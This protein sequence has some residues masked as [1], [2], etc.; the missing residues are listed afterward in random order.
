MLTYGD[1]LLFKIILCIIPKDYEIYQTQ[2]STHTSLAYNFQEVCIFSI[3]QTFM[4]PKSIAINNNL[5]LL[6]FFNQR[7]N[8]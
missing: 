8:L 6:F 1:D 7:C 2:W 5:L 3:E 4:F